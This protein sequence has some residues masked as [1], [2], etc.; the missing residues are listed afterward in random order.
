MHGLDARHGL[1]QFGADMAWRAACRGCVGQLA[2]VLLRLRDQVL[3]RSD[4]RRRRHH[5]H[6][7]PAGDQPQRLKILLHVVRNLGEHV[8]ADRQRADRPDA[9]R[10][11][12][13]WRL[14]DDVEADGDGRAGTVLD[15]RWCRP[16][17]G[18][19]SAARM[20]ATVSVALPAACGT[21]NRIGLSGYS[22]AGRAGVPDERRDRTA[23]A[24]NA[25]HRHG[26]MNPRDNVLVRRRNA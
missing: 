4:V 11:A 12:V 14:R 9:E 18:P 24:A 23:H 5:E 21:I 15:H 22:A 26:A 7:M 1:E 3:D 8:R 17:A 25:T 19:S 16:A 13:R 6:Q 10:V 20:R 2:G